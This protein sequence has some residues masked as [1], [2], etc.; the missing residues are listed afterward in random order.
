MPQ[1]RKKPLPG[2]PKVLPA[3]LDRNV[4]ASPEEIR[5]KSMEHAGFRGETV[6]EAVEKLK[7]KMDSEDDNVALRAA[8]NALEIAGAYPS[9]FAFR[10]TRKGP[11]RHT[12]SPPGRT[13]VASLPPSF[14]KL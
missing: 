12:R 11:G 2:Q 7:E 4:P 1:S 5:L 3:L 9:C 6:K 13:P 14:A 8:E 10:R